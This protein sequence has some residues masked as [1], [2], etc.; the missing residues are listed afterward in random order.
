MK[1]LV[2][3]ILSFRNIRLPAPSWLS[4]SRIGVIL[5]I[6]GFALSRLVRENGLVWTV[7]TLDDRKKA[8]YIGR[9]DADL[10]NILSAIE[11][12]DVSLVFNEQNSGKVKVRWRANAPYDVSKIAQQFGGG[13][14]PQA[15]GAEFEGALEEVENK[16]IS[17]TKQYM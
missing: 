9:D 3:S 1:I 16:V 17:K 8:K 15:S 4:F 11:G 6:W 2:R 12:S 10:T 14:H 5:L 13:G 7:I